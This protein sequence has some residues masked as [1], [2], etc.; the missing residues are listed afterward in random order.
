M[1]RRGDLVE[2]DGLLAVI[3]GLP[4]EIITTSQGDEQLP[5]DHVALWYG[6]P[7]SGRTSAGGKG[8]VPPEVWTV[9]SEYCRAFSSPVLR[10]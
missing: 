8:G 9:P 10:H 3:V 4:G 1:L 2:V 5:G 7:R 6:E